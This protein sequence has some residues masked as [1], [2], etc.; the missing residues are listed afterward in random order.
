MIAMFAFLA[1][2][3]TMD[4]VPVT[5][6]E[7]TTIALSET[8]SKPSPNGRPQ[9]VTTMLGALNAARAS[10]GLAQVALDPNLCLIARSHAIDM[11][12]RKYFSHVSP[13]GLS[14]F[15]RMKRAN[16]QF[17]YAGENIALNQSVD[18]AENALWNSSEHRA[19]M[20][21]PHYAKVGI[22]AVPSADGEIFVED[23]S[24]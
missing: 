6:S 1:S 17:G 23:F 20:L 7:P 13:E 19:N 18:L 12:E 24:D 14:P 8:H 2:V 16:Y 3:A 9:D 11:V 4:V 21:Q 5:S 15:D 22:A 10:Q